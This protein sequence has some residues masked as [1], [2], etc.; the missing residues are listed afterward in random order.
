MLKLFRRTSRPRPRPAN[1]RDSSL[2]SSSDTNT[3]EE[4]FIKRKNKRMMIEL[5]KMRPMNLVPM[6]LKLFVVLDAQTKK[7]EKGILIEGKGSVQFTSKYQIVQI[8]LSLLLKIH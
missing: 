4:R 7:P 3:D 5:S 1:K 8:G 6:L 2:S